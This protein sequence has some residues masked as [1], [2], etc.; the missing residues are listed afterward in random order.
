MPAP[1][2][3]SLPAEIAAEVLSASARSERSPGFLLL[4]ALKGAGPLAG[5]RENG[6]RRSVLLDREEDDPRDLVSQI[7]KLAAAK[8]R[9]LDLDT[10]ATLAWR[11]RRFAILAWVDRIAALNQAAGD[12][13]LDEGLRAAADPST[14]PVRLLALAESPY[15]R[16][17]A[18]VAA[19]A[20]APAH[21][22]SLLGRDGDR[23]VRDAL[24][25]R[26]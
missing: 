4:G 26:G 17:R 25:A 12:D 14:P 6:P 10:A 21:A 1:R 15:P 22:L 16:V 23:L 7:Q 24:A 3:L 9:E 13:E 19:H 20:H 18:L 11:E 2:A 5:R 8:A